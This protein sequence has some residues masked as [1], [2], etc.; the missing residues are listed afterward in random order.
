MNYFKMIS[1]IT[2]FIVSS[3]PG[4]ANDGPDERAKKTREIQSLVN[5]EFKQKTEDEIKKIKEN[6]EKLADKYKETEQVKAV[7]TESFVKKSK[8]GGK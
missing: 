2:L 6:Q 1:I 5:K 8:I 4:L 7:K 3:L